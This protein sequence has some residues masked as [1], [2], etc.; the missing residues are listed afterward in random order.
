MDSFGLMS[1]QIISFIS[2]LGLL[3]FEGIR[4]FR[5]LRRRN[6]AKYFSQLSMILCV[7]ISTLVTFVIIIQ[8]IMLLT[9]PKYT[10]IPVQSDGSF[11]VTPTE[12]LS[13]L[14][15]FYDIYYFLYTYRILIS[16]NIILFTG[17]LLS[18]LSYYDAYASINT[19]LVVVF[20]PALTVSLY[21]FVIILATSVIAT[22]NFGADTY[23]F[24][25]FSTSILTLV[26]FLSMGDY[27]FEGIQSTQ[28]NKT[29]YVAFYFIFILVCVCILFNMFIAIVYDAFD[30]TK[31]Y[32]ISLKGHGSQIYR[33]YSIIRHCLWPTRVIKMLRYQSKSRILT[34][35]DMIGLNLDEDMVKKILEIYGQHPTPV[36]E[37]EK[38]T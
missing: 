18:L 32:R 13:T 12:Y 26:R 11:S 25:L 15:A 36:E 19:T 33:T 2:I 22:I 35:E 27:D 9:D 1:L 7:F 3:L 16:I 28:V 37:D 21:V 34:K 4:T 5:A 10:G 23:A 30:T 14:Q 8:W 38:L 17:R 31:M 24:A 6:A 20:W 29:L